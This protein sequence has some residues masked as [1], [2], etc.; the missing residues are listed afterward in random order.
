MKC[1]RHIVAARLTIGG[2][3]RLIESR[4][5]T[6]ASS[7]LDVVAGFERALVELDML[8]AVHDFLRDEALDLLGE[9]LG[10]RPSRKARTLSTKK[11]SPLGKVAE[12]AL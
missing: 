10:R 4:H 12:S 6:R 2:R 1:S 3:C 8:A 11:A 5:S 9:L 7:G